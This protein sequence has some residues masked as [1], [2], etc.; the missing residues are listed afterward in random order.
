[1]PC[2]RLF[3]GCPFVGKS[4]LINCLTETDLFQSGDTN[5]TDMEERQHKGITYTEISLNN[6]NHW[7]K[8]TT[9]R[10]NKLVKQKVKYQI[11]F[12]VTTKNRRIREKDLKAIELVLQET[13]N[14]IP[15]NVI[16][17][18]LSKVTYDD[19]DNNQTLR[20]DFPGAKKMQNLP[21]LLLQHEEYLD[22]AVNEFK[23]LEKLRTFVADIPYIEPAL[24]TKASDKSG[25]KVLFSIWYFINL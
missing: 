23:K 14:I 12:V 22:D 7:L 1:M 16:I 4:T 17:N 15:Y 11:Y 25:N 3:I 6:D 18:K 21:I 8:I 9:D 10:I 19:L 5:K 13:A 20:F 2:H 24:S